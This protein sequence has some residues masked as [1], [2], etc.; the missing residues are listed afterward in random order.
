[1]AEVARTYP[2]QNFKYLADQKF[3][4][5]GE[6]QTDTLLIHLKKL[7]P[8]FVKQHS[9]DILVVAC[10]T[11]STNALAVLRGIIEIPIIGVVPAIKPAAELS[12]TKRIGILATPATVKSHYTKNL[13]EKHA[14]QCK[15]HMIGNSKLVHFAELKAFGQP[16]N[17]RSLDEILQP[18]QSYNIDT[19]VLA[20]THFP[21]LRAELAKSLSPKTDLIDSAKGVTRQVGR[22]LESLPPEKQKK[23]TKHL[24]ISTASHISSK[25]LYQAYENFIS[26]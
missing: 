6:K 21:F 12:I 16:I 19:V 3:F 2:S 4:P 10:N 5:Y 26:W 17:L 15:I 25:N 11:A 18:L 13:I 22:I 24:L 7:V 1:M 8:E 14:A 20:C 9:I 23:S